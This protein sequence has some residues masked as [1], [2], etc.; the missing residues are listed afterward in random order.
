MD[1]F[2]HQN[3]ARAH[4]NRLIFLFILA[5][6]L[7]SLIASLGAHFFLLFSS[8][9]RSP[10]WMSQGFYAQH[11]WAFHLSIIGLNIF[12]I[13]IA[14]LYRI[15]SLSR[16]GGISIALELGARPLEPNT[17]NPYEKRL[18]N[19]VEEMSIASGIAVPE[20]FILDESGINAFA[21]GFQTQD[22]V[23]AVSR[24][25]M[26]T[27]S[28]DE[29]QGV[30]AHEF[31]H[32]FHGDM[33]LNMNMIGVL[34]GLMFMSE[35][36]RFLISPR[37]RAPGEKNR[38]SP[39]A[40][41]GLG[42]FIAGSL[43]HFLGKLIQAAISRKREFLADASAVQ[44]TRQTNGIAGALKKIGGWASGSEVKDPRA[45]TTSHFFIASPLSLGRKA[46]FSTH[47]PLEQRI[48]V[49]EPSFRGEF[50]KTYKISSSEVADENLI[51]QLSG[52]P[53][54]Q[55][56]ASQSIPALKP[57]AFLAN[58]PAYLKNAVHEPY[59][60]QAI[61]L[62]CFLDPNDQAIDN[63][64]KYYIQNSSLSDL[65]P[66]IEMA[67]QEIQKKGQYLR[68]SLID[69]SLPALRRLSDSQRD[70]FFKA[71]ETFIH[72][73]SKFEIYE[74]VLFRV[75]TKSLLPKR[76]FSEGSISSTSARDAIQ[77]FFIKVI[78]TTQTEKKQEALQK[79]LLSLGISV[80]SA[81]A[82]KKINLKGFHQSFEFLEK[83]PKNLRN[84]VFN[85]AVKLFRED[86]KISANE[87]EMLRAISE[88]FNIPPHQDFREAQINR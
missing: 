67:H 32:I 37:R 70:Y 66:C 83:S 49:L 28:R 52:S 39:L 15:I 65:W 4:T 58:L 22:A 19:V 63:Q 60:A 12:V 31:S 42:L 59:L 43:G 71:C 6:V 75:L 84:L 5:L 55:I 11:F 78:D 72:S 21:A 87:S 56:Q 77:N 25:A 35:V 18:L 76:K 81:Q 88:S 80:Q 50:P 57:T 51:S 46:F 40:L 27:L 24:G 26:E 7:T 61:C 8:E 9:S 23:I 33:R 16:R 41:L 73:D 69:L 74:Y 44:Y 68:L 53:S 17:S 82:N 47:P 13:G 14:S 20:T 54:S 79:T 48:K 64:K 62:A 3:R 36:G 85:S 86:G 1:F 30:V 38:G 34:F 45:S 29:L 10:T 2:E